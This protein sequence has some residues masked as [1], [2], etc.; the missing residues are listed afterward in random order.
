MMKELNIMDFRD[1]KK[2][3]NSD[4]SKRVCNKLKEGSFTDQLKHWW[5]T[6]KGAYAKAKK[7]NST[8]GS[9]PVTFNHLGTWRK[10]LEEFGGFLESVFA[11][12]VPADWQADALELILWRL[13]VQPISEMAL[14][15]NLLQ[16]CCRHR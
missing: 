6:L 7:Q 11:Q 4:I 16:N 2:H 15:N 9:H 12:S 13:K 14:A 8:I 10:F 5:K 1:A 3:H